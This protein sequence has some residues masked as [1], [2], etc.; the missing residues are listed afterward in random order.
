DGGQDADLEAL[1]HGHQALAE[2]LQRRLG[3]LAQRLQLLG[4]LGVVL[5]QAAAA[6][7]E[8]LQARGQ[9]L[10]QVVAVGR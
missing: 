8:R 9:P 6:L 5:R 7:L 2:V 4:G 10:A 1:Q 3:L